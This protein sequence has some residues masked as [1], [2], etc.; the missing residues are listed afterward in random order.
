MRPD[1][2]VELELG[3]EVVKVEVEIAPAAAVEVEALAET[4]AEAEAEVL[5]FLELER[6]SKSLALPA[7]ALSLPVLAALALSPRS[8][9]RGSLPNNVLEL[10]L[11]TAVP[12]RLV[13][14]TPPA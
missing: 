9:G 13:A 6:G 8:A 4:E 11:G 12:C 5:P 1:V 3:V 14:S 7:G 10:E 2:G